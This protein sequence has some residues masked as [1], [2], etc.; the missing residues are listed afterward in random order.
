MGDSAFAS[1]GYGVDAPGIGQAQPGG[2]PAAPP[3]ATTSPARA[4]QASAPDQAARAR[5]Y[6]A[7]I[8]GIICGLISSALYAVTSGDTT[9]YG[10][11]TVY[12]SLHVGMWGVVVWLAYYVL[13]EARDGQT[14]GKRQY[15]VRVVYA[16]GRPLDFRGA[17]I[18]N[19][20]RIVDVLPVAY[21]SGLFSMLRSGPE[22]RQR[23]GDIAART[24]VVPV[25]SGPRVTGGPAT[26]RRLLITAVLLSAVFIWSLFA[27]RSRPV[28]EAAWMDSCTQSGP[29]ALCQCMYTQLTAH[30]YTTYGQFSDLNDRVRSALQSGNRAALP[31]GYAESARVCISQLGARPAGAPSG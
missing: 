1:W 20:L 17:L 14:I 5:A 26:V 6:A 21:A 29:T 27:V 30:G 13:Q 9:H 31:S 24:L 8:D 10:A 15:G 4:S 22:C 25:E 2:G 28:T 23:M 7:L 12:Y 19:V 16:D 11:T 18:R 3:L